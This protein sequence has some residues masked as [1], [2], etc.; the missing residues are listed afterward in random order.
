MPQMRT[1]IGNH[2]SEKS[3]KVDLGGSPNYLESFMRF[4][5]KMRFLDKNYDLL[6]KIIGLDGSC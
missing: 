6:R 4:L 5:E 1:I 2:K 3:P